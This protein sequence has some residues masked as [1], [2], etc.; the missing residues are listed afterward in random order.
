M[1]ETK[2]V[3]RELTPQ[4]K[5]QEQIIERMRTHIGELL[6]DSV[7]SEMMTTAL[8]KMFFGPRTVRDGGHYSNE[9]TI[10]SWFEEQAQALLK[11]RMAA[12]IKEH[13]QQNEA[14]ISAGVHAAIV[15]QSPKL[16][17]E[18][19]V[20]LFRGQGQSFGFNIAATLT[21]QLRAALPRPQGY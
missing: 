16:L 6:P 15:E 11:D 13:I 19:V 10:P 4:E 9:R 2:A 12:L 17:A 21:E 7:L 5:F 18:F 20:A 14:A 8:K 1:P 3:A